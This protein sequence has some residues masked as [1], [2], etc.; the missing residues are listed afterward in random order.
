[1]P[2]NRL[3]GSEISGCPEWNQH[4]RLVR[5]GLNRFPEIGMARACL[6]ARLHHAGA[7]RGF[8]RIQGMTQESE[9]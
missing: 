2:K 4:R 1:M 3:N 7:G 6:M 8:F 9:S 5:D